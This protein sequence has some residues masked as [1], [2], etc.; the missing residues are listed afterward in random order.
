[1][2]LKYVS[3]SAKFIFHSITENHHNTENIDNNL[4]YL[5][6]KTPNPQERHAAFEWWNG[7][8]ILRAGL[9]SQETNSGK[10]R[11]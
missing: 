3:T 1:M 11:T 4:E 2:R 7:G 6:G 9:P 10:A 5:A 8:I